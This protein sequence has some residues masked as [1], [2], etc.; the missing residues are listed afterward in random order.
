MLLASEDI[1]QKQNERTKV[2]TKT[3]MLPPL[4]VP[5]HAAIEM[6]GCGDSSALEVVENSR[7]YVITCNNIGGSGR[8]VTCER[9]RASSRRLR[10]RQRLS[11]SRLCHRHAVP[12]LL[13]HQHDDRQVRHTPSVGEQGGQMLHQTATICQPA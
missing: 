13:L 9:S 1:K 7:D 11:V 12:S 2:K 6:T 5:N 3:R 10:R 8:K 4:P